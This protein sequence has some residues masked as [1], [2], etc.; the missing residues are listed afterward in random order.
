[1]VYNIIK[2]YMINKF[3]LSRSQNLAYV[4]NNLDDFI[5]NNLI[6][7]RYDDED[8]LKDIAY[9]NFKT[10]YEFILNNPDVDNDYKCLLKLHDILMKDLDD[11]IKAELSEDQ[12][13]ELK[14]MIYQPTKSNTEVAIDVMLYILEKRLFVDG[15]VRAALLFSNK[16]MVD[17]GCGFITISPTYKD[18]F[19]EKLREY[20]NNNDYDIKDW[21]YKYCIK[22]PK[23]EY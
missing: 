15:D 14:K 12:I 19:R 17:N 5:N 16:I 23:L 6:L 20:K 10:A 4:K 2:V 3:V 1:M 22:G 11:G 8:H 13:S 9:N 21:I 18:T 7:S